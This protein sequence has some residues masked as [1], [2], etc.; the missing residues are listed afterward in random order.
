MAD[1]Y[2][3]MNQR[4]WNYF[5]S[6]IGKNMPR[7]EMSTWDNLSNSWMNDTLI[8]QGVQDLR[9]RFE[10]DAWAGD[11]EEGFNPYRDRAEELAGYE[12][13]LEEFADVRSNAQFDYV[14]EKINIQTRRRAELEIGDPGWSR[15]IANLVDPINFIPIPIAKGL[16]FVKGG[17]TFAGANLVTMSPTEALRHNLDPTSTIAETMMNVGGG[18]LL[19]GVFGG[20]LGHF[21]AKQMN[22]LGDEM[23][24]HV[25][26]QEAAT[27]HNEAFGENASSTIRARIIRE[28]DEGA[29]P[30]SPDKIEAEVDRVAELNK[31]IDE[32]PEETLEAYNARI[33]KIAKNDDL[34]ADAVN[35]AD[36]LD[37]NRLMPTHIGVE[38]LRW[39]EHPYLFLKNTLFRGK[40]GSMI[41]GVGD[42]LGGAPGTFNVGN[43]TGIRTN[44]SV[45]SAAG[46]MN[47][48]ATEARSGIYNA[49]LRNRGLDPEG[50]TPMAQA[51]DSIVQTVKRKGH[52]YDDFKKEVT[53][54]YL[55]GVES[56]NPHVNEAAKSI[57]KYF[58]DMGQLGADAGV[59]AQ[60]RLSIRNAKLEEVRIPKAEERIQEHLAVMKGELDE[61][62]T[63]LADLKAKQ[64]KSKRGALSRNQQNYKEDLEQKIGI[65]EE[66]MENP[67]KALELEAGQKNVSL[68]ILRNQT[69]NLDKWRVEFDTNAAAIKGME[70][71][72]TAPKIRNETAA[73]HYARYFRRSVVTEHGDVLRAVLEKH[74]IKAGDV[75]ERIT[76]TIAN[77]TGDGAFDALRRA[78]REGMEEL[79]MPKDQID[80]FEK[81]LEAIFKS[82]ATDLPTKITAAAKLKDEALGIDNIGREL[83]DSIH[84]SLKG[85]KSKGRTPKVKMDEVAEHLRKAGITDEHRIW[86]QIKSILEDPDIKFTARGRE[87]NKVLDRD[88]AGQVMAEMERISAEGSLE[89]FGASTS[90]MERKLDIPSH[91]LINRTV[92]AAD[93]TTKKVDFIE[94]DPEMV[95]RMY[96][97][98]MSASIA[99]AEQPGFHGDPTGQARID[100][101]L[102]AMDDEIIKAKTEAKPG[103]MKERAKVAQAM[104]DLRQKTLGVYRIPED[105][106]AISHRTVQFLKNWMVLALMGKA[107][108]AA[109][110]DVGRAMMEVGPG[111]FIESVNASMTYAKLDFK[112]G[113]KEAL[114]AGEA[115]EVALHGR[116]N[117]MFD[118]MHHIDSITPMERFATDNVNRM[119]VLN[120]L[121]PYTDFMKRFSGS[122]IQSE[123]IRV[124]QKVSLGKKLTRQETMW[125]SRSGLNAD[126]MVAIHKQWFD[127]TGGAGSKGKGNTLYLANTLEWADADV[128]RRFRIALSDNIK[129]AVI[130][131]GVSEKLNFMST[132]VGGLVTQFKSFGLAATHRTTIAGLQMKDARA[133]SGIT[134]LLAAGMFVDYLKSPSYDN[135]PMLSVDRVVQGFEYSGAGG[136]L[137][138]LSNM[139]EIASGNEFGIKPLLGV[140]SFYSNPNVAQKLGQAFGPTASLSADLVWSMFS[141]EADG[142]DKAR[143]VKRLLPYNNMLYWSGV[144]DRIQREVGQALEL[145]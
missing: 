101:I 125:M 92:T 5:Q 109:L 113:G 25:D 57:Q 127:S 105:P 93:G 23:M 114:L 124:S 143:S 73:G 94:T 16:G 13:Y 126:D 44:Q 136:L 121:S 51:R 118:L 85:M 7:G 20:A 6:S 86:G 81:E 117:A 21:S 19:G 112:L 41:S 24:W 98:R 139:I 144:G 50:M 31:F 128:T 70:A 8:G 14:M 135:R 59:F 87:V 49:F 26:N 91:L 130:T 63:V 108:I 1:F 36:S 32:M 34:Y 17:A 61:A 100:D 96:H 38:K 4:Q 80:I 47:P 84:Q 106:S 89:G 90:L 142:Y 11:T 33:Q 27:R 134:S 115:A 55:T 123:M 129:N 71:N 43:E 3:E 68:D 76:R 30:I 40:V 79:N 53:T 45:L 29:T 95:I 66:L 104:D 111:K 69:A 39:S 119:F 12:P 78:V 83:R 42:E 82:K 52:M 48:L 62:K 10:N 64:E 37:P 72:P 28:T 77:I 132:P 120:L 141:P 65:Y 60:H 122:I 22:S 110:A 102:D 140:D 138:D 15:L 74:Y 2:E 56:A 54:R 58:A 97:Q 103:M 133:F 46:L 107:S 137:F 99:M 75:D 116:W 88:K 35:I 18:V 145:D 131:P 9:L 67:D